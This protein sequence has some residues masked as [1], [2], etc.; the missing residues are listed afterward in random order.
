MS[1]KR[2]FQV[3]LLSR[4]FFARRTY[5]SGC[6]SAFLYSRSTLQFVARDMSVLRADVHPRPVSRTALFV[7]I[8]ARRLPR[9]RYSDLVRGRAK[10]SRWAFTSPSLLRAR[11]KM[12]HERGLTDNEYNIYSFRNNDISELNSLLTLR[13]KSNYLT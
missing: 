8:A 7:H 2:R 12:F 3:D 1:F 13:E 11:R 10:K 5:V 4:P 9:S 6:M